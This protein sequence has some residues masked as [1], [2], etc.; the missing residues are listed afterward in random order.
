MCQQH[1]AAAENASSTAGLLYHGR[2][3]QALCCFVMLKVQG[4]FCCVQGQGSCTEGEAAQVAHDIL[5]VL[6]ECHQQGILY[7]DV[8]PANFLL[9][10]PYP[11]SRLFVNDTFVPQRIQ[12]KVADFGCAQRVVQVRVGGRLLP[13]EVCI[14]SMLAQSISCECVARYDLPVHQSAHR[15]QSHAYQSCSRA[16]KAS[17][18]DQLLQQAL[19]G[20]AWHNCIELIHVHWVNRA[21]YA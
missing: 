16:C 12:I 18:R 17:Y 13:A 19:D 5:R 15:S 1:L 2:P 21:S 6:Q 9:Q 20:M 7:A 4:A 8:K 3:R 14:S 10:Q 11:D